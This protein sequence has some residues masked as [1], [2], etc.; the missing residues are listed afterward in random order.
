M[1]KNES[2][3]LFVLAVLGWQWMQLAQIPL[4]SIL[5]SYV[6]DVL[7]V[8]LTITTIHAC[9]SISPANW[10]QHAIRNGFLPYSIALYYSIMFEWIIP[11]FHSSFTADI[12]DVLAYFAGAVLSQ[13]LTRLA[14]QS[15][16]TEVINK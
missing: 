11:A 5:T 16:R 8:P 4:P 15:Q 6:D 7:I 13:S 3:A 9:A 1:Q 12:L 2:I 10:S 14:T